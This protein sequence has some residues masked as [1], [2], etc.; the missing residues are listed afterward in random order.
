MQRH[1]E[2]DAECYEIYFPKALR[3]MHCQRQFYKGRLLR[4]HLQQEHDFSGRQPAGCV[5]CG[6]VFYHPMLLNKHT[7]RMHPPP[8]EQEQQEASP[9]GRPKRAVRK[10]TNSPTT[11]ILK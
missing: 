4:A 10:K 8:Q 3:C 9:S 7:P 2:T 1:L 5:E 6:K 11:Q